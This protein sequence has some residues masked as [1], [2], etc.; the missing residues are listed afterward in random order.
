M[1]ITTNG[2]G[3]CSERETISR[4][5]R[6][7][8]S[9]IFNRVI[10]HESST[11]VQQ[12]RVNKLEEVDRIENLSD[13]FVDYLKLYR[14]AC[15]RHETRVSPATCQ[16]TVKIWISISSTWKT[17]RSNCSERG[18]D[19]ISWLI[20]EFF[21]IIREVFIMQQSFDLR[22]LSSPVGWNGG[23]KKSCKNYWV[24]NYYRF[25]DTT[26]RCDFSF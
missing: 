24:I 13:V 4:L 19:C 11:W 3:K 12:W 20:F 9:R 16:K 21:F 23:G 18:D 1:S 7:N 14:R 10:H 22:S 6:R 17:T 26:G 5:S 8:F 15:L 2:E 25:I